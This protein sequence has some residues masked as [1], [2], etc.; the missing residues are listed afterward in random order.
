MWL[1]CSPSGSFAHTVVCN[2]TAL[3]HFSKHSLQICQHICPV[4]VSLLHGFSELKEK[5][6]IQCKAAVDTRYC[7]NPSRLFTGVLTWIFDIDL[8]HYL[9]EILWFMYMISISPSWLHEN[10]SVSLGKTEILGSGLH[11]MNAVCCLLHHL[12]KRAPD[13]QNEN[14]IR[15]HRSHQFFA[16]PA[17]EGT[18]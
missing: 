2:G 1:R 4:A 13:V 18:Y 6:V 8:I 16:G 5:P 17:M 7:Q 9:F 12:E 11:Q 15:S 14:K 10:R 3:W